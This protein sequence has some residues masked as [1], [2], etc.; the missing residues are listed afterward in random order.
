MVVVMPV[1]SIFVMMVMLAMIMV[2]PMCVC[3]RTRLSGV[4]WG[5]AMDVMLNCHNGKILDYLR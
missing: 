3:D 2:V 5:V 4:G 1:I